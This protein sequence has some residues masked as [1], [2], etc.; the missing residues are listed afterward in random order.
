MNNM[1]IADLQLGKISCAAWKACWVLWW[2]CC[3]SGIPMLL[4][5][6]GL[7]LVIIDRVKCCVYYIATAHSYG[8]SGL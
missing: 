2:G 5:R 7:D 3:Y 8:S 4:L 6:G 1:L